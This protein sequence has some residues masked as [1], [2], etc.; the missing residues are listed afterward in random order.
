[1]LIED[2]LELIKNLNY[3]QNNLTW[4]NNLNISDSFSNENSMNSQANISSLY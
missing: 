4:N 1:M 2:E 3:F